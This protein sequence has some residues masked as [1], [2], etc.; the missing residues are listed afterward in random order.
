M[1]K[2]RGEAP[3]AEQAMTGTIRQT[4]PFRRSA[5]QGRMLESKVTLA[6]ALRSVR[7]R[8]WRWSDHRP[9][10]SQPM[11]ARGSFERQSVP[12]CERD[13]PDQSSDKA[14]SVLFSHQVGVKGSEKME[15][16]REDYGRGWPGPRK[17]G[18]TPLG[19]SCRVSV[20]LNS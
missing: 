17:V 18:A 6:I 15:K 9:I 10:R 1:A 4:V 7:T 12:N 5:C 13:A 2:V 20:R 3:G 11:A 8:M 16:M 14:L 19:V